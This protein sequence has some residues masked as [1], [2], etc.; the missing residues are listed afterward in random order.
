MSA[1]METQKVC[2]NVQTCVKMTHFWTKTRFCVKM[3]LCRNCLCRSDWHPCC[4]VSLRWTSYTPSYTRCRPTHPILVKC[5]PASKPIAGSMPVNRLR[6]WPN[7]TPTLGLW[8]TL[9]QLPGEHV[10]IF[11][12]CCFNVG[13]TV[14]DAGPTLRQHW[15][16]VLCL[17]EL[18]PRYA[19]DAFLP[20]RQKGHY[21]DNTIH[22]RNA[23]VMLGH[24]LR[25]WAN[26]IPT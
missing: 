10:V 16:I 12:Q 21:P 15:M 8:N 26:I 22:L 11:T 7:T 25:H 20:R 5:G 1:W 17:L 3:A 14:F 4:S 2:R 23:D 9:T 6:R 19:D 24:R 13:T 18:W